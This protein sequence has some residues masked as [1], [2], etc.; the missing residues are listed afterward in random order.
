M[1]VGIVT[2]LGGVWVVSIQ[3]GGGGVDLGTWDEEIVDLSSE[4]LEALLETEE[5]TLTAG[6]MPLLDQSESIQDRLRPA[7]M[8]RET[9]SESSVPT[10]S[11]IDKF[12]FGRMRTRTSFST[13]GR[14]ESLYPSAR[15]PSTHATGQPINLLHARFSSSPSEPLN[16][17]FSN[18]RVPMPQATNLSH[19]PGTLSSALGSALQIGLSP[20]SP[21]FA[22]LPLERKKS[23]AYATGSDGIVS[24]NA[25]PGR[26]RYWKMQRRRTISDGEVSMLGR[27]LTGRQAKRRIMDHQDDD[28]DVLQ[29]GRV[30]ESET[31]TGF[32]VNLRQDQEVATML[33]RTGWRRLTNILPRW[34]LKK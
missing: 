15:V 26:R 5:A 8:E 9:A 32:S 34:P 13:D 31:Q 25:G 23:P 19:A 27:D 24:G 10:I 28:V 6:T 18:S 4:D 3:S 17:L 12:E 21:G 22:I 16:R 11:G 14:P 20:V 7:P 2:L 29:D 30:E 33:D 1:S